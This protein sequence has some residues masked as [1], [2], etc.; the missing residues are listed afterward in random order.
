MTQIDF[1]RTCKATKIKLTIKNMQQQMKKRHANTITTNNNNNNNNNGG[2]HM[3]SFQINN[4][5]FRFDCEKMGRKRICII[6]ETE[7]KK[8][9]LMLLFSRR[10]TSASMENKDFSSVSGYIFSTALDV[11]KEYL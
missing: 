10:L 6:P 2:M 8:E 3:S 1:T 4:G 9:R 11:K 7:R 5:P